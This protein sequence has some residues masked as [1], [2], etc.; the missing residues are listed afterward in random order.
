MNGDLHIH[1]SVSD[2]SVPPSEI[3]G[4]AL[5]GGLG[6]LAVTDHNSVGALR[7]VERSLSGG[8]PRFIY[9]VELSAQPD[10]GHEIHVL[11]YGVDPD[12]RALLDACREIKGL[13]REQLHE[14]VS[15]LRQ[16]GVDIDIQRVFVEDEEAYVGRP[17]VAELLVR[18]GVVSSLGQAFGRYLGRD[19]P[20]FVRMRPF[21]PQRCIEAVHEAG[22]LAVLA[23]PYIETV[24]RWL[25]PLARM[26]LDGVEAYRPAPSG[27]EELYV[28]KAAEHFALFVT[29]GS[30][31][32]GREGE[33]PLGTFN[34]R[35]DQMRG[36]FDALARHRRG[37]APRR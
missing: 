10:E 17:V 12:C 4:K 22:G 37:E 20:A 15:R 27:N 9:G 35:E 11:G 23:H 3:V 16:D 1:T 29:G 5:E 18:N 36:F 26:G 28:E 13:K 32:H 14:I 34:V 2:G 33:A 30:D 8:H 19:A 7:E 6:F 31:W 25:E 24:D 21:S